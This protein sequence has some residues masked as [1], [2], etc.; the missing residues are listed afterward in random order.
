[1]SCYARHGKLHNSA[2]YIEHL[3]HKYSFIR[4]HENIYFSKDLS[5]ENNYSDTEVTFEIFK[6]GNT[7]KK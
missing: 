7:K 2:F 3:L 1:M 5:Q 4:E 6:I